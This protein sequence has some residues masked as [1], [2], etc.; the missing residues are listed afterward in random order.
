MITK[1]VL[2]LINARLKSVINHLIIIGVLF[3]IL[4]IAILFYPGILQIL[5]VIAFFVI[6]FSAFLIAVKIN[7]IKEHFE[8]VLGL[9]SKKNK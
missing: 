3:F 5:F 7:N 9:A 2:Q 6:S 1:D 8:K 4:A